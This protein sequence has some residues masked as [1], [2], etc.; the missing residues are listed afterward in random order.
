MSPIRLPS[1][2]ASAL[3]LLALASAL[4][5]GFAGQV[6]GAADEVTW[7]R[8]RGPGGSGVLP[9]AR[10][11]VGIDATALA[12]KTPVPPGLSSPVLTRDRLFL[13][14]LDGKQLVTLAFDPRSGRQLWRREA[15]VVELEKVHAT[16]S[17]AAPTPCLDD[18]RVYVYFGSFGLLCYDLEGVEQWR[19]PI[20]TPKSLYGMAGSPILHGDHLILVLDDDANLPDSRL[21][22]S[23][24]LALR[25]STGE[26]AWE[27]PRPLYRSGWS[28]PAIW[29]HAQGQDLVVLGSGRAAGYDPLRGGEKWNVTG[30][31]RETIAT[32]AVGEGLVFLSSAMLGGVSDEQPDLPPFWTAML[33]FDTNRDGRIAG[34]EATGHFTFPLR[35]DLPVSHPGF[36]I[37][38]NAD[39]A[40]RVD[41]QAG[42]FASNDRN[43]DG[44]WTREEF[45]GN[46]S[47]RWGKPLLMAL[48][49][50]G[51]G[52][53]TSSHVAWE[54]HQGV[55]EIPS[56]LVHRGRL[57]LVRNGGI[58]TV[59]KAGDG[60][61]AYSER[62][63]A[64]G[65]YGASP[66]ATD[67]H[68]Y[69]VSNRGVVS[70]VTLGDTFELAGQHDLGEP[71]LV[72]PAL[73]ADTIYLRGE[74]HIHAFRRTAAK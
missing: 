70:V 59:V 57:H 47:F 64:A 23:R 39:P 72:T 8:F 29:N 35:P 1:R 5:F 71:V 52:D 61:V 33:A 53:I 48:R 41:Q 45:L 11:P 13:T 24:I 3:S 6:F 37:P 20:P 66:V 58:L 34:A 69:I 55:P 73:D 15:P 50:G 43:K 38:L 28:T 21:S 30:F 27:T 12:W 16:S 4:S 10:P 17:P 32:P 14:A 62:L 65:Q 31:S 63:G 74:T 22:R 7:N 56:P 46:L 26:P 42:I 25:K 44:F 68:L 9:A 36:G 2:F 60:A 40:K 49:P 67:T 18:Q 51:R 54:L 19:K